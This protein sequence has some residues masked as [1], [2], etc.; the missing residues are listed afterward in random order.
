MKILKVLPI[1]LLAV[2]LL[3]ARPYTSADAAPNTP[4][5]GDADGDGTITSC[6]ASLILQSIVGLTVLDED[7]ACRADVNGD[8]TVGA[9]DAAAVLRYFVRLTDDLDAVRGSVR[10]ARALARP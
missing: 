3:A 6:D 4:A 8:G 7:A 2:L 1:L 5:V 10:Q 9:D